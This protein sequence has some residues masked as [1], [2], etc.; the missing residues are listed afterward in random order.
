MS[1][2]S[3]GKA[4]QYN[5]TKNHKRKS[6]GYYETVQWKESLICLEGRGYNR[7]SLEKL[8]FETWREDE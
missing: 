8:A 1:L 7:R 5:P 4:A 2:Q 3:R 6:T